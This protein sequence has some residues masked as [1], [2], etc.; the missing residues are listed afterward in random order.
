MK[1][2]KEVKE[3]QIEVKD[4]QLE[5]IDGGIILDSTDTTSSVR[6]R[7]ADKSSARGY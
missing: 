2:N 3:E 5:R 4:E 6:V 1:E 7:T